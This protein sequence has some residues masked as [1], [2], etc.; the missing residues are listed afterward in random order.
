MS[1]TKITF[2]MIVTDPDII[3]AD[4]AVRSYANIKN[5]SFKLRVY[6]NWID[7]KLKQKYF[8][9]WRKFRYV[10]IVD[11]EWQTADNRP[12]DPKLEGP[13]EKCHTVWDR[14]LKQITTP[15]H[16]TVDAD[17]EVLDARFIP[18]ML[19]RLDKNPKLVAMSTDYSPTNLKCYDSYSNEMIRLN[20]RWHTWFCIY[21]RE[22]LQCNI[23]HAYHE[24]L[25]PGLVRRNAWDSSGFFQKN[26][27]ERYGYQLDGLD[28]HYQPF[29]IHYSA[30]SKNSGVTNKN[31]SYTDG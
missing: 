5:I 20:E 28:S 18:V 6:S 30:F 11:N 29:F 25:M 10:E 22:A 27:K 16:A 21:K 13:F 19:E 8:P 2:F 7:P 17:F 31:I 4:Y 23:S 26:L 1:D 3:I 24:E 14:E 12:T 15:Y 9:S